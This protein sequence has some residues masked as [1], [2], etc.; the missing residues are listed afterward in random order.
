MPGIKH[1]ERAQ[2]VLRL[3]HGL[4][5]HDEL[6]VRMREELAAPRSQYFRHEGACVNHQ[7]HATLSDL[8]A[9]SG[10]EMFAD[11]EG[12]IGRTDCRGLPAGHVRVVRMREG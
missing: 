7:L 3:A 9:L 12:G 10:A 8:A 4:G 11:E 5:S 1:G 6:A 2:F